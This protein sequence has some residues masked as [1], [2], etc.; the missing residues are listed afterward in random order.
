MTCP[1]SILKKKDV[2][3]RLSR[4]QVILRGQLYIDHV[5]PHAVEEI[6][7]GVEKPLVK[8][9]AGIN[10]PD[11]RYDSIAPY[12][13]G[14]HGLGQLILTGGWQRRCD[15]FL[16]EIWPHEIVGHRPQIGG[17]GLDRIFEI[18]R[19]G[20]RSRSFVCGSFPSQSYACLLL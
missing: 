9:H 19:P 4:I 8:A 6:N 15:A 2:G 5:S 11:W 12:I 10:L 3:A 17:L 7:K 16:V 1:E 20:L 18:P 14:G 13:F